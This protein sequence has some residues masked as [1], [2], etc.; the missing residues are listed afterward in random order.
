MPEINCNDIIVELN[1]PRWNE[2]P[3][4]TPC[5]PVDLNCP[6][7]QTRLQDRAARPWTDDEWWD[8]QA[9][10]AL[11]DSQVQPP[12]HHPQPPVNNV[13]APNINV[14]T[15]TMKGNASRLHQILQCPQLSD[16]WRRH[17]Q[18]LGHAMDANGVS[19]FQ[20]LY[21]SS[22]GSV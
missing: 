8:R 12:L 5:P 4:L 9:E 7:V 13:Q 6:N 16:H 17:L 21:P 14:Y 11:A 2:I 22:V 10:L 15:I 3:N 18:N 20:P 1:L 19:W